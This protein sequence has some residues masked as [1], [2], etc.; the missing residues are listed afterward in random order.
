VKVV[1]TGG[2]GFIGSHIAEYWGEL[3]AEVKIID[4]LRTG[5]AKNLQNLNVEFFQESITDLKKL[6]NIFEGTD[7]IFNLAALVSVPESILKP[8]ECIDINV[9]GLINL[10]ELA[11]KFGIKKLVHSSSAAIYGDDP[12][13]PKR[14]SHKPSPKTPYGITKL[15]G[16]Y[17][18][19]MYSE[20]F[21]VPAVSLR[22][23]NVFGPR[24]NPQSQYAAAIP[25]FISRALKSQDIIIYGKGDQTRDFIFVKDVVHANVLAAQSQIKNGVF[26]VA[27]ENT[28][29]I[30]DT[31]ELIINLTGS[32]SK[33]VF[34]NER[35]GDI[36]HSSADISETKSALNFNPNF[37]FEQG[38]K[39][40]INYFRKNL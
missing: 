7:Y 11:K 1:I 8:R 30:I 25:I 2:A 18:C 17:Y 40:T 27:T 19:Q 3:G 15:D 28:I 38:L 34:E 24:Q 35:P 21:D 31:A 36:K 23:F 10:L 39:E 14:I 26:N 29:S 5:F 9:N 33:I 6:E 4:S 37:S 22:Y 20:Q 32:K 12:E 13:Q 16:E